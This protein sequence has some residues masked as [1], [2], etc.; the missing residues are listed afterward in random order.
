MARLSN[1]TPISD[2]PIDLD[3][4]M[5]LDV[6]DVAKLLRVSENQVYRWINNL[7][8]HDDDGRDA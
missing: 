6:A 1:T 2:G 3:T 7:S 8:Y 4:P 5:R